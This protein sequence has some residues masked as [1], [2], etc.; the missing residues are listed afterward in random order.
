[1]DQVG[2]TN[3]TKTK[4]WLTLALQMQLAAVVLP[5][6]AV[7]VVADETLPPP[8][9][10][11]SVVDALRTGIA[12]V[13]VQLSL[14]AENGDEH[15]RHQAIAA[16]QDQV[17]AGLA[18]TQFHLARKPSTVPFLT[19]EI[20]REALQR[21]AAMQGLVVRVYLDSRLAPSSNAVSRAS[22]QAGMSQ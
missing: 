12:R 16:A 22:N 1:M 14:A 21:L 17:L 20:G 18:G 19:L 8:T 7:Q 10:D 5:A 9:I 4:R 15:N 6:G 2:V 13:T 11:G 3:W